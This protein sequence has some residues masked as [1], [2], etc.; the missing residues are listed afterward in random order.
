[1]KKNF[2][3]EKNSGLI[4]SGTQQ[5]ITSRPVLNNTLSNIQAIPANEIYVNYAKESQEL[6][7]KTHF[8]L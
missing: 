2:R 6:A 8:Q 4:G 3:I 1:M 5:P 7:L